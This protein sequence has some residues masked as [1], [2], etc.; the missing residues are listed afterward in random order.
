MTND[1][2]ETRRIVPPGGE[3]LLAGRYALLDKVGE[4]GAAEVYRARDTRLD[5]I[6]AVKLLRR[7]YTYDEA[8]RRRFE[9]EAR[10]AARLSHPNIVD[11][12]DFGETDDGTMYLAMR[13]IEGRSLKELIARRGRLAPAEAIAIARQACAA[14]TAAHAQGLVHRD[15]KPQNMMVDAKGNAHLTDF[16]VVKALSGPALTQSG[17][18][19]GTAAYLS[20][21]QATGEQVGPPSD[22]YALGCVMYEMLSGDPPF[23][24]DNPAVV[25]YKQVWEQPRP[26]HDVAP[27]VPPSLESIVMRCLQKDPARRYPTASALSADLD[28]LSVSYNQPTQ[29]VSL[30]QMAVLG[31]GG[32][33]G[34]AQIYVP[35]VTAAEQ[36]NA[37]PMPSARPDPVG[38]GSLYP[39]GTPMPPGQPTTPTP[40][41]L[42]PTPDTR[43]V[44]RAAV[45][46]PPVTGRQ[47]PP[48]GYQANVPPRRRNLGW[49]PA[50]LVG[51]LGLS[52]L[53]GAFFLGNVMGG[54]P[55]PTPTA[56]ATVPVVIGDTTTRT[57]TPQ[58]RVTF[59]PV[60]A[61]ATSEPAPT[62]TPIPEIPTETPTETPV[63]LPTD[64]P[65][66]ES[67][68]TPE[69]LPTETPI[70]LPT[71]NPPEPTII[72]V[73][74]PTFEP[75]PA[76]TFPPNEDD[77]DGQ[78]SIEDNA[79]TGGYTNENRLYRGVTA[80]WVYGQGTRYSSM[81]TAFSLDKKQ[82]GEA[83]LIMRGVDSEDRAKTPIRI[84]L[85]DTVVHEGPNPL[86]N[87]TQAGINA[88]G[89]WGE[90]TWSVPS[91]ALRKGENTLTI[92]N[93]SPSDC[94]NCPAFFMLDWA[95]IKWG[96]SDD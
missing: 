65:E 16:G 35:A 61:T 50:A 6:V 12:Y 78:V 9:V 32:G 88:P 4:G 22:I 38:A 53:A 51:V 45:T 94:M 33:A 10:A 27:E 74:F 13:F 54:G 15:V 64:T 17:M 48:T 46:V 44:P 21:E 11:I 19:F 57:P 75:I 76:P 2:G 25:A 56:T 60:I 40:D 79:F 59:T 86:P 36:S 66:P 42:Y 92:T 31:A 70:P 67:T 20:P 8:S 24:G 82:R 37:I 90:A 23:T 26:L 30:G 14:L 71:D 89:N 80:R 93:L 85:N 55:T 18:T 3:E 7:Q 49:L 77:G 29:A 95:V 39:T 52:L 83:T 73:P 68:A 63:P 96:N 84:V 5:R 58:I 34:A 47:V 69:P 41:P 1:P 81:S 62:E 87:D 91:D 72:I 28:R 43:Y